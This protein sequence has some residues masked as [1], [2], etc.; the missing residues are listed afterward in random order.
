MPFT[1]ANIELCPYGMNRRDDLLYT[2][3]R[4][5]FL[6]C[7]NSDPTRLNE[8]M[9]GMWSNY[10][11]TFRDLL[12]TWLNIYDAEGG[13]PPVNSPESFS[14]TTTAT[15]IN[16][17]LSDD[18]YI[19]TIIA[20]VNWGDG[21]IENSRQ[22]TPENGYPVTHTFAD[23]TLK[24][25]TVTIISMVEVSKLNLVFYD[26]GLHSIDLSNFPR[27]QMLTSSHN[28]LTALSLAGL[29]ILSLVSLTYNNFTEQ[30]ITNLIASLEQTETGGIMFFPQNGGFA[31]HLTLA[32]TDAAAAKGWT[33]PDIN[34]K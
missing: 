23:N 24:T 33:G 34:P 2:I 25:V 12:I 19:G 29:H 6:R 28:P 31:D 13:G 22:F 10:N 15:E 16:F 5:H 18:D 21:T 17:S 11:Q 27:V 14:F 4:Q 3:I 1:P 32:Q 8:L 20:N 26:Q 9:A 30:A 7:Y